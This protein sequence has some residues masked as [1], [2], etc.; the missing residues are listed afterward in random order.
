MSFRVVLYTRTDCK[1]C[2]D[3]KTDLTAL[4]KEISFDLVEVDID[5]DPDLQAEY[6]HRVPVIQSGPFTLDP[7][8]DRRKLK[9]TLGAARDSQNQKL[10]DHGEAYREK[11]RRRQTMSGGDRLSY[12]IAKYYLWMLN[13]F[14]VIYVGLPF[15][16]PVLLKAGFDGAARPIYSVYGA[17]CHKLAFRSWFLFGE[18]A[19]YPRESAGVEGLATYGEVTG[20][21]EAD[22]WTAR[23]FNGNEQ[24]GYKVSLCERDIAIYAAML[25]FGLMYAVS[26]ERIPALPWY[27][28]LFF[29][30]GPIGLDG[31]SQLLSQVPRFFELIPYR[32][33]TPFLRTLTGALFGFTTAWFGFPV[34]R[35]TMEET[36][37]MLAGKR[38]RAESH[39]AKAGK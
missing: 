24:L 37:K 12:F 38:A 21:D 25:I 4:K 7:P 11:L 36:R 34:V 33:S 8:F 2:D 10:E 29:G 1:L 18:Q 20:F 19:A 6:G 17:T 15:L 9:M 13:I 14:L 22:L 27:I 31:F 30:I 5:S 16:A 28:W 39:R 35:E 23:A 26:K 3:A 32:E